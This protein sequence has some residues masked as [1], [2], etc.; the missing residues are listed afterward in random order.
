M[1]DSGDPLN[2]CLIKDEWDVLILK[3]NNSLWF[4]YKD[5]DDNIKIQD[6]LKGVFAKNKRGYGPTGKIIAFD[7]Y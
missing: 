6:F 4:L 7:H 3:A 1:S 2:L 5:D